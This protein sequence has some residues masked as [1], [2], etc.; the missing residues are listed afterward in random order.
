MRFD[1]EEQG[2]VEP[3]VIAP[4][5][6]LEEEEEVSAIVSVIP[7]EI[8]PRNPPVVGHLLL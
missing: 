2:P 5:A 7:N 3:V 1:L 4:P 6:P 8:I